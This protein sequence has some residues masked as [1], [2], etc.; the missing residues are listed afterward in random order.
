VPKLRLLA[1]RR[2]QGRRLQHD[3]AVSRMHPG[4]NGSP[5]GIHPS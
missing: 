5:R 3:P 4:I 2:V 1:D